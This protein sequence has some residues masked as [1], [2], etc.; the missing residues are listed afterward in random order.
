MKNA[1]TCLSCSHCC[2]RHYK[3]NFKNRGGAYVC[4]V[5]GC[6]IP[7]DS[8]KE[9]LC[10]GVYFDHA[11]E[12][13]W[14]STAEAAEILGVGRVRVVQLIKLGFIRAEKIGNRY[15]VDRASVEERAAN[16]PKPGRPW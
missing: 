12:S 14:I 4:L 9:T 3:P 7:D 10:K 8:I 5:Y 16:S 2:Q 13:E 6:L 1:K 15:N 11:Q